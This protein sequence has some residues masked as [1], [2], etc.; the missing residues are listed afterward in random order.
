MKLL[1]RNMSNVGIKHRHDCVL[2]MLLDGLQE[3]SQLIGTIQ[4]TVVTLCHTNS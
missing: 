4:P 1:S 3:W 2:A